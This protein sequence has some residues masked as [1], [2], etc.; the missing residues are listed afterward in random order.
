MFVSV[1]VCAHIRVEVLDE[2]RRGCQ[3][4]LQV[5]VTSVI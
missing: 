1:T 3:L 2:A 5:R 4:E